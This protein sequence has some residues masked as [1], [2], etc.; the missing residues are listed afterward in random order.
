MVREHKLS[1]Q[2]DPLKELLKHNIQIRG[3]SCGLLGTGVAEPTALFYPS[4]QA[5]SK[6]KYFS[7]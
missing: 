1:G 3:H 4:C 2:K 6:Q 5:D 7:Y